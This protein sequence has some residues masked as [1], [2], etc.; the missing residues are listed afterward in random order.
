MFDIEKNMNI[1]IVAATNIVHGGGTNTLPSEAEVHERFNQL[2]AEVPYSIEATLA[3]EAKA[4]LP[5]LAAEVELTKDRAD[6]VRA[7]REYFVCPNDWAREVGSAIQ[8]HNEAVKALEEAL[9][10]AEDAGWDPNM[11]EHYL[12]Q[13]RLSA[14]RHRVLRKRA[15]KAEELRKQ[16]WAAEEAYYKAFGC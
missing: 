9:E 6:K 16:H 12:P 14:A 5:E 2:E 4:R 1:Q 3:N 11:V 8:A 7:F 10:L 15:A 13:S